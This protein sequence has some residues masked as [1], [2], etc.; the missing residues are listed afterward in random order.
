MELPLNRRQPRLFWSQI[1]EQESMEEHLGLLSRTADS[2]GAHFSVHW[3]QSACGAGAVSQGL[4]LDFWCAGTRT[5]RVRSQLWAPHDPHDP[6]SSDIFPQG[7]GNT[8]LYPSEGRTQADSSAAYRCHESKPQGC[9]DRVACHSFRDD[10]LRS[11][12]PL[13]KCYRE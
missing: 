5:L 3:R 4:G 2:L 8:E 11:M 6:P 13:Y 10:V 12:G 1:L 7:Q 9:Q